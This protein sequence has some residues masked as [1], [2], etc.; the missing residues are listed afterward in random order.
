MHKRKGRQFTAVYTGKLV[1]TILGTCF[2]APS[3]S[4]WNRP[5]ARGECVGNLTH[6]AL[7]QQMRQ[8]SLVENWGDRRMHVH[9]RLCIR[10][11][12]AQKLCLVGLLQLARW[13]FSADGPEKRFNC[14]CTLILSLSLSHTQCLN[15]E[16]SQQTS[17]PRHC[18][19]F[20][21]W[22]HSDA[23]GTSV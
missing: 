23:H 14:C 12:H 22:A 19:C 21:S 13:L 18:L 11:R 10:K 15:N 5:H 8:Q 16:T 3:A 17:Y 4:V 20:H 7:E 6:Q 2:V 9:T 1:P